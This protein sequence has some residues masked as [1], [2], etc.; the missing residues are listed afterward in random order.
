[1]TQLLQ[2]HNP[3]ALRELADLQ[4]QLRSALGQAKRL[5]KYSR[6]SNFTPV[7][8]VVWRNLIAA[9]QRLRCLLGGL[10][11]ENEA[12]NAPDAEP[13]PGAEQSAP[14]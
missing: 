2:L 5:R 1:M 8:Q 4:Q 9:E 7:E 13:V 14:E 3:A 12:W 10:T 6:T 11:Q